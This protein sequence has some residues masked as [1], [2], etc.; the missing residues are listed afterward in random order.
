MHF[1]LTN[2]ITQMDSASVCKFFF[3]ESIPNL[4]Y[5]LTHLL[6]YITQLLNL[7]QVSYLSYGSGEGWLSCN[8]T[9]THLSM[10]NSTLIIALP[11]TTPTALCYGSNWTTAKGLIVMDEVSMFC[12]ILRN[13]MQSIIIPQ[14]WL[15]RSMIITYYSVIDMLWISCLPWK[16]DHRH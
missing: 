6:P 1:T 5:I 8:R 15:R 13:W 9:L 4:L 16:T 7:R 11:I 3:T 2:S 10:Q 14:T 12:C